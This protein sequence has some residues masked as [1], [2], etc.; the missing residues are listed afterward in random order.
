MDAN[1]QLPSL[2]HQGS[3]WWPAP[4]PKWRPGSM[5]E[6]S[7]RVAQRHKAG[8]HRGG[9]GGRA[10]ER[11]SKGLGSQLSNQLQ[12]PGCPGLP[13]GGC[14]EPRPADSLRLPWRARRCG[15]E[16]RSAGMK[17]SDCPAPRACRTCRSGRGKQ[18]ERPRG[19]IPACLPARDGECPLLPQASTQQR[20]PTA[21]S[22]KP[23]ALMI[24]TQNLLTKLM[25]AAHD[26]SSE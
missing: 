8:P 19:Q 23:Q 22:P 7:G 6:A 21:P 4:Q 14:K 12:L 18:G 5:V 24:H 2:P 16:H 11:S 13:G 25:T 15:E 9:G 26:P 20:H 3:S 17:L 1:C 10:Q